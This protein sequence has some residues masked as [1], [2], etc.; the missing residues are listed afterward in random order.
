MIQ[1]TKSQFPVHAKSRQGLG[2]K[3]VFRFQRGSRAL[4]TTAQLGGLG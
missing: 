3:N 1:A 4:G 2:E